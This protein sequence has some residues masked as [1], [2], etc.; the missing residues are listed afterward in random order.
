MRCACIHDLAGLGH[1]SLTAAIPILSVMGIQACPV[2]TAVLSSQTDGYSGYSFLDMTPELPAYIAHWA[3]RRERFDGIFTGFLGSHAQL[4]LVEDFIRTFRGADT[5]VVV[6]PVMG[7][8]GAVYDTYT[9]DLCAGMARAASLASVITPNLTEAAQLLG[10][11]YADAPRDPEGLMAWAV[12]LTREIAPQAVITGVPSEDGA[13]LR[14]AVCVRGEASILTRPRVGT[15]TPCG[16]SYPGTG[17]VF[18]S[19]LTGAL[20]RGDSLTAAAARAADFTSA[21]VLRTAGAGTPREEGLLLEPMLPRL[22]P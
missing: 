16:G 13:E 9:G 2:P 6:D 20:L 11:S 17:D 4:A 19:V 7:D 21:C 15:D 1:C 22:I 5:L 18:A 14:M 12:R 8:D 3:S 10:E